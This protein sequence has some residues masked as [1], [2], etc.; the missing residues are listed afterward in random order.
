MDG[1][2]LS[3]PNQMN[4]I[5]MIEVA[6]L[7]PDAAQPRKSFNDEALEE[8]K[9]S[10]IKNGLLQPI[11][12]RGGDDGEPIV[13][14]AG[15]RR[16]RAI[17]GILEDA[18]RHPESAESEKLIKRFEKIPAMY[19]EGDPQEIALVEN[20]QREDLNPVELA[21]GLS[22]LKKDRG[23][24]NKDIGKIIGKGES[25]VS[26]IVS[27]IK[28]PDEVLDEAKD[29]RNVPQ[30]VLVECAKAKGTKAK[31]NKWKKLKKQGLT[32]G[33]Y[34]KKQAKGNK[35]AAGFNFKNN[36][37]AIKSASTQVSKLS[38]IDTRVVSADESITLREELEK[39]QSE[40]SQALDMLCKS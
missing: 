5:Y 37:R 18:R 3:I 34:R 23:Y 35:A 30:W 20:I 26:E 14:V 17:R 4:Q 40:V 13:I 25:S 27:I 2:F 31:I 10:I 24:T 38:E 22:K 28:L 29:M 36:L 21:Q 39:L 7:K 8:L 1:K 19:V 15:E 16:L 12:F 33:E 6:D 9:Q 32:Q 11:L